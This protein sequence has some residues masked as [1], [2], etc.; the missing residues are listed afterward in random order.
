MRPSILLS[1]LEEARAAAVG[2][3]RLPLSGRDF[4]CLALRG[5]ESY[6]SSGQ[7]RA[8]NKTA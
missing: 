8:V 4:F 5:K 6:F 7:S 2:P 3:V 1:S